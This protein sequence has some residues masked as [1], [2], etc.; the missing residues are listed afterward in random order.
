MGLSPCSCPSPA[1]FTLPTCG[2]RMLHQPA[3]RLPKSRAVNRCATGYGGA[4]LRRT[5]SQV[6]D[7][8]RDYFNEVMVPPHLP[9][10]MSVHTMSALPPV[11]DAL[12][13]HVALVSHAPLLVAQSLSTKKVITAGHF[14]LASSADAKSDTDRGPA[15]AD[16]T[17]TTV[18]LR[19]LAPHLSFS[20]TR[21]SIHYSW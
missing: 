5:L 4:G 21:P 8:T 11:A 3:S 15:K 12:S 9:T 13:Q 7:P 2:F 17:L 19:W 16:I 6:I 10:N 18:A 14:P 20:V 1:Y